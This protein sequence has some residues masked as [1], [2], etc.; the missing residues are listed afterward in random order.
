MVYQLKQQQQQQICKSYQLKY[1]KTIFF[2]K[3]NRKG[4]QRLP[5]ILAVDG[6]TQSSISFISSS[7]SKQVCLTVVFLVNTAF[8]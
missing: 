7:K 1:T 2:I 3:K 5:H 8:L 4:G 6:E